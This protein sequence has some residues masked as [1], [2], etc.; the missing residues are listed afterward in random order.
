MAIR[1]KKISTHV[2]I[3]LLYTLIFIYQ[4][5]KAPDPLQ[6]EMV[7]D[8]TGFA[9]TPTI[10]LVIKC[11]ILQV[12]LTKQSHHMPYISFE[13]SAN[14]MTRIASTSGNTDLCTLPRL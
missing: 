4:L 1:S 7:R 2:K 5:S 14:S 13:F 9:N 10:G 12:V 6:G 3:R 11:V 8:E